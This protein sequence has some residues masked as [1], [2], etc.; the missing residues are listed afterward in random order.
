MPPFV[1]VRERVTEEA[2]V[3]ANELRRRVDLVRDASSQPADRLEFLRLP[4]L[5]FES[6]AIGDVEQQAAQRRL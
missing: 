3:V 1:E 6:P 2:D 4:Q 5:V